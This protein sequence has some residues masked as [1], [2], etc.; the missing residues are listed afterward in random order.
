MLHN[1]TVQYKWQT[2]EFEFKEK[3]KNWFWLVGFA[4]FVLVVIAVLMTNYLLAFLIVLGV[5]LMFTQAN[6]QPLDI[7]VEISEK[8]VSIHET[9]HSFETIRAFWL[10][11]TKDEEVMLILLTSQTMT[12]IESVIVPEDID[13]L[14]LREYLLEFIPEEELR[15]SYTD[16]LMKTIGF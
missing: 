14:E 8:G 16:R 10:K 4:G 15:E 6:S 1:K 5:F 7:D 11:E 12:P 3:K 9:M 2:S 13:P